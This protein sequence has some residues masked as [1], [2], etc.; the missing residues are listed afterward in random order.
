MKS[1]R[2]MKPVRYWES[3]EHFNQGDIIMGNN[4][5][6]IAA[7]P[8]LD[9]D[10]LLEHFPLRTDSGL[11]REWL[12]ATGS[13]TEKIIVLDDDPTGIQTVH[14]V[15]VYTSCDL[16]M[17]HEVFNDPSR[18]VYILTNSRALTGLATERLHRQLAR[19]LKQVA[20]AHQQPYLLISR[21][22]STLRG[23]YPLETQALYEELGET[24]DGEIIIPFFWEGGRFTVNDVHYVR[25]GNELI[26]AGRTE[27]ARDSTFGYNSSD[28]KEWV[29]EKTHGLYRAGDVKSISLEMLRNVDLTGIGAV[30]NEVRDFNKV[31]VNAVYE[32]DLKVLAIGLAR[33]IRQGKSFLF[34][35]AASFVK[36][37]GGI[38][39]QPL[40]NAAAL[41]PDRRP[42]A[43]GLVIAGSHVLKT[44]RQLE[45][46]R[47][48]P[49]FMWVE[50]DVQKIA[51]EGSIEG[52][53]GRVAG[54]A[55]QA[56]NAGHDVC[57][58][59][60]RD[61]Y[62]KNSEA[63]ASENNLEFSVKISQALV[64]VVQ[65]LRA[66]PGYLVAKG[67]ITSSDIGVKGLGVKRAWAEGQIHPGVPVWRTGS[68]S[69]Y[70]GI[71]YVIFPG[72][73]GDDDAVKKVVQI[74]KG[75]N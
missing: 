36:I 61:Y 51:A 32:N 35:T 17:F 28:L 45:R 46:L 50:L 69:R 66:R 6:E 44:T 13:L 23:H 54:E 42:R 11:E 10:G 18:V 34:R 73:V 43:P 48:L 55:E 64:R 63:A 49:G 53:A 15:P 9:F 20:Q 71:P 38:S 22:D 24:I 33:A 52:E 60:S 47:D 1:P 30:L 75:I 59:T 58:F 72:N 8:I 74:L 27:F 19:D 3:I 26:P 31:I 41:Y 29:E 12:Q 7:F 65:R 14:S 5:L 56:L 57:V 37:I 62:R 4:P 21:S 2:R 16:E 70:P 67:G 68:E 25:D 39:N 40:L